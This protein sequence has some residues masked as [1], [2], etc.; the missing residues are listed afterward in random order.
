VN[1]FSCPFTIGNSQWA[2]HHYWGNFMNKKLFLIPILLLA[3]IL[4]LGG[5]AA[6]QENLPVEAT[7]IVPKG[8][9][10]VGDPIELAISV[11]HPAEYQVI[12][13][14]L[15][16]TWGDFVVVSQSA[17]ATVSN[18]DGTETTTQIVD[19]RL[20]NPG[21][22][23]TA[24]LAI[25]VTDGAG[26]IAEVT[27]SPATVNIT[28]V[29]V[30]GDS[31]LRDIKPQAELSF[32]T[33]WPWL[34][35]GALG[36]LIVAAFVWFRRRKR[37]STKLADPRLPYE[38]AL[39]EL[40]RIESLGLPA[41]G[42][43]KEHYTLVSDCTRLYVEKTYGFP[44]LERT[45]GEIQANLKVSA[46]RTDVARRF[47]TLLDESDLVKF[48]K[49][50][51]EFADAQRMLIEARWIV[52]E[53]KPII[54]EEPVS[55]GSKLSEGSH[56]ANQQPEAYRDLALNGQNQHTEVSA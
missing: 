7:V 16:E 3:G 5:P 21:A 40:T 50:K 15:D 30:E 10:T 32:V 29:L 53:T 42:R 18:D 4:L 41:A 23:D 13:P 54:D 46:V 55:N 27:A 9:L 20:F 38:V 34:V 44:V 1:E 28:S 6:A 39:D 45:T 24:P 31:E 26:Q 52:E 37:L 11:T 35:A 51:P 49:F 12:M 43:F 17:P 33:L 47:V 56:T 36:I 19:V 14:E 2:I 25:T 22:F 8:E 48:S